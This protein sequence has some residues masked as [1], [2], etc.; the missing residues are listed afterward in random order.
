M[1]V[2]QDENQDNRKVKIVAKQETPPTTKTKKP[3]SEKRLAALARAREAHQKKMSENREV[4]AKRKQKLMKKL[5]KQ[6]DSVLR[7]EATTE[8]ELEKMSGDELLKLQMKKDVSQMETPESDLHPADENRGDEIAEESGKEIPVQH[9]QLLKSQDADIE[10]RKNELAEMLAQVNSRIDI[11]D[12]KISS[13]NSMPRQD[14]IKQG[15]VF[16]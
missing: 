14:N 8:K 4:K 13:F 1:D 5:S 16:I 10:N 12:E 6:V 9:D 3:L 7:V 11:L 2:L 15:I